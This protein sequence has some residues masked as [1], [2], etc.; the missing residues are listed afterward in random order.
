MGDTVETYRIRS[1]FTANTVRFSNIGNDI[2][3]QM[4]SL[5]ALAQ[6]NI[7]VRKHSPHATVSLSE[8]TSQ[9]MG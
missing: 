3:I 5:G 2:T 9:W 6:R 7:K 1:R 4:I 8:C